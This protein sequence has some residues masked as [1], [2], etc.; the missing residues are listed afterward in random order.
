M[1]KICLADSSYPYSLYLIRTLDQILEPAA[2]D[3]LKRIALVKKEMARS[4]E[5]SFI[6][7]AKNGRL[8]G[9]VSKM[10][11]IREFDNLSM[12]VHV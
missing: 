2:K 9:K 7:A 4:V 5:D 11:R 10:F 8:P 3:R 1:F 6:M 12:S